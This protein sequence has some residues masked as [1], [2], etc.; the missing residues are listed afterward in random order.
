MKNLNKRILEA[1]NTGIKM[2]LSLDD[3]NDTD[4]KLPTLKKDIKSK[5]HNAF[6]N[7]AKIL[8]EKFDKFIID[9]DAL[10]LLKVCKGHYKYTVHKDFYLKKFIDLFLR[11]TK[12]FEADLNWIDVS[13]VT[14]FSNIFS[15]NSNTI[16]Q[17]FNGDISKWDVHNAI[18]MS[19]MFYQSKFNGD[20]SKWDVHNVTTFDSMF[21]ESLFTGDISN[22]DVSSVFDMSYMFAECHFN[23]DI[24]KW[25]VSHVLEM[26]YMFSGN[27]V[28][29]GDISKW[30]I[31][32]VGTMEGMF[33]C[34]KFNSDISKWNV[35]CVRHMSKMFNES[36]FNGDISNWN[37]SNVKEMSA[38]FKKSKFTGDI[39]KW[40][41][42]N[43]EDISSMFELS[44]FGG[45]LSKWQ[46]NSVETLK[47]MFSD[48][49]AQ[50]CTLD[51]IQNNFM[52]LCNDAQQNPSS[53]AQ[54]IIG[55]FSGWKYENI[56]QWYLK[57]RKFIQN[58]F[59]FDIL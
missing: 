3:F 43:V 14:D 54:H 17:H 34:T 16:N 52:Q 2:G 13:Q 6:D 28:F 44:E 45:D 30:N 24:S 4:D 32:R 18:S 22:W 33:D 31:K 37:V 26:Q 39:S 9:E 19:S 12:N 59:N 25:N 7:Y 55:M 38:M 15:S 36:E 8:N 53:I 56:P 20:I 50:I 29:N 48:N 10:Y 11:E 57:I 21:R 46:L 40:N 23:G 51:P 35:S 42:S 49:K 47:D 41:V 27:P 1:I 5:Y 58:K